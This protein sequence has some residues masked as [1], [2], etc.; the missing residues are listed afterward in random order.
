MA[1]ER[2]YQSIL[3]QVLKEREQEITLLRTRSAGLVTFLELFGCLP[4]AGGALIASERSF[5]DFVL[6]C[7]KPKGPFFIF[8]PLFLS[9]RCS[10]ILTP[11][12]RADQP[13]FSQVRGPRADRLA[14]SPWRR[15]GGR[16]QG[17]FY[18]HAEENSIP[19]HQQ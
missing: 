10:L 6:T 19:T 5:M 16:G 7:S 14:A 17:E 2:E 4:P 8:F 12:T 3:Q 11:S 13:G 18:P 1:K 15:P 9:V